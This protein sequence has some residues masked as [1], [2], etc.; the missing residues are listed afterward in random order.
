MDSLTFA[1]VSGSPGA[2]SHLAAL[3][4]DLGRALSCD[5]IP[6]V[7]PSYAALKKE[8]E[9]G[10]A[11]IV[12]APP[13]VA[14]ELEDAGLVSIDLC[15][16]RGGQ[17]DYHA[18]IFTRHASPLDAVADLKGAHVAWVD[19]SSSAGYLVP[20]MFLASSGLDPESLF[21]RESFLGTHERV[22]CAVLDGEVDAGA[23][24]LSLDPANQRPLSAG[25]LE[26]G[27][28]INGA[29]I[30]AKAGPIPS[31]AIALSSALAPEVR[32]ALVKEILAL[33]AT[34]PEPV[35]GLL[36]ADGFAAPRTAHFA[37]LRKLAAA[38]RS[39]S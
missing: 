2:E 35:G 32:T 30:L 18:A 31:D 12:W 34:H 33:P 20:R 26:A 14:V 39:A 28:G 24:Y 37:A 17:A 11:Q 8:V 16:T 38:R 3:C 6:S 27:A 7:Q 15:C 23:T 10:Q 36:R 21:E 22:A 5:V 4:A 25:W 19:P 1:V 29:F 13:L 9:N